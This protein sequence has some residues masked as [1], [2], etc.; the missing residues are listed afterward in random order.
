MPFDTLHFL[1][2]Y[3]SSVSEAHQEVFNNF[4]MHAHLDINLV[5]RPIRGKVHRGIR[6]HKKLVFYAELLI[7]LS[8]GKYLGFQSL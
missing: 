4:H 2:L 3:F 8:Y 7:V 5:F 6:R 1:V